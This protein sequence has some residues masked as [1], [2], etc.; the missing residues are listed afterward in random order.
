METLS[1][2]QQRLCLSKRDAEFEHAHLVEWSAEFLKLFWID[3]ER[4]EAR[5]IGTPTTLRWVLDELLILAWQCGV[6]MEKAVWGK[7]PNL[8]SYCLTQPCLCGPRKS[9]PHKHLNTP[10]PS[11]GLALGNLQRM[12]GNIYPNHTSLLQECLDVIEETA[13]SSLEVWSSKD[14]CRIEEEFADIF[15]RLMRVGNTLGIPLEGMIT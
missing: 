1:R 10:P 2:L 15:A 8:C 3:E 5:F 7:Y 9:G 13:E 12:L 14:P 11:E 4:A 6:D